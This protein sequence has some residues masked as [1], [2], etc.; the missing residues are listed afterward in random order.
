M[1]KAYDWVMVILGVAL[2]LITL[3]ARWRAEPRDEWSGQGRRIAWAAGLLGIG[4]GY[5]LIVQS[6]GYPL[7]MIAL[8][9]A[10]ILYHGEALSIKLIAVAVGGAIFLWAL[11]V[12][13]LG[14]SMP[15]GLLTYLGL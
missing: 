14:V 15:P 5:L 10:T 11:F 2:C 8:I 12:F 4:I 9:A 6:L 13:V 1:P 3:I 7:A